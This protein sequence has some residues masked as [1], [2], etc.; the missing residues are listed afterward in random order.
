[1]YFI[2]LCIGFKFNGLSKLLPEPK[3]LPF[4]RKN[5]T[6]FKVTEKFVY[7][8]MANTIRFLF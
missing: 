1:M 2:E 7:R 3:Y 6:M 8:K 5:T 4:F